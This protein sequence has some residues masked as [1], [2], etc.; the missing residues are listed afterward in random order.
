MDIKALHVYENQQNKI[1]PHLSNMSPIDDFI[2]GKTKSKHV[3]E[4]SHQTI[5]YPNRS[6]TLFLI[7]KKN[8]DDFISHLQ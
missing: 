6:T 1:V 8:V 7:I 2:C 5:N 4:S 3:L